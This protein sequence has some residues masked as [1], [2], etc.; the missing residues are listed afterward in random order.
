[1]ESKTY[2]IKYEI[3]LSDDSIIKDKEIKIKRCFSSVEAQC[4]LEKFLSKKYEKFKRQVVHSCD[5]DIIS[6]FNNMFGNGSS[7]PF[8]SG[9]FPF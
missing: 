7:N 9:K 4:K 3:I 2:V 8:G 5:E 6:I 1:M